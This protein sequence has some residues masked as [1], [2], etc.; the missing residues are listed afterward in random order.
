MLRVSRHSDGGLSLNG[1][2]PFRA[3]GTHRFQRG[4][5][6]V[7]VIGFDMDGTKAARRYRS[8]A[9]VFGRVPA[10]FDPAF[11]RSWG[12]WS[13]LLAL[14][15]LVVALIPGRNATQTSKRLAAFA[16]LTC[17]VVA[18][19]FLLATAGFA[20]A[21]NIEHYVNEGGR[22]RLVLIAV[23]G[24]LLVLA[25]A[26]MSWFAGR[27]LLDTAH[28]SAVTARLR[29][30]HALLMLMA[31]LFLIFITASV[32]LIGLQFPWS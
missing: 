6:P 8:T 19:M 25:A 32:R 12:G 15:A 1:S 4:N 28:G 30:V 29:R 3:V 27:S 21:K 13:L 22:L 20:P 11:Q 2:E 5:H 24:N 18:A 31:G 16:G 9:Q 26:A 10:W 17:L 23:S 7:N 14:S